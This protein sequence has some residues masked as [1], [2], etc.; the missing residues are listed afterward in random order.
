MFRRGL[1]PKVTEICKPEQVKG[2]VG[3]PVQA[4]LLTVST[5]GLDRL[6]LYFATTRKRK[7]DDL[8][9]KQ[10][11]KRPRH[12]ITGMLRLSRSQSVTKTTRRSGG[13]GE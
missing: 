10:L 6:L 7:G 8:V 4:N 12:L 3:R 1:E 9:E 5:V 2:E 11:Q 13:G